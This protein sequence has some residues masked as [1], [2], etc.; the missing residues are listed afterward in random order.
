M[1]AGVGLSVS[2]E[3]LQLRIERGGGGVWDLK[4]NLFYSKAG[5]VVVYDF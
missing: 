1:M 2:T 4:V 3:K 5:K